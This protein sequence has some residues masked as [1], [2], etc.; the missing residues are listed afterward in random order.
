MKQDTPTAEQKRHTRR[1]T[2]MNKALLKNCVELGLLVVQC[3]YKYLKETYTARVVDGL[4]RGEVLQC[5]EWAMNEHKENLK[6]L[7]T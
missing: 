3:Q 2:S 7:K 6:E 5:Y 1:V 4:T